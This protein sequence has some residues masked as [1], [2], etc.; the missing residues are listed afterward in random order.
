MEECFLGIQEIKNREIIVRCLKYTHDYQ[1]QHKS[2]RLRTEAP[3]RRDDDRGSIISAYLTLA[4]C[5]LCVSQV[6]EN[7][8]RKRREKEHWHFLHELHNYPVRHAS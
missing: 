1:E 6:V 7:T 4:E 5:P 8:E 3:Q 2:D